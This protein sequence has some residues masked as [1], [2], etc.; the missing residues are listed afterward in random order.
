MEDKE[1]SSI[2]PQL[3]PKES[4]VITR[5]SE[6]TS[7]PSAAPLDREA[8]E[9]GNEGVPPHGEPLDVAQHAPCAAEPREKIPEGDEAPAGNQDLRARFE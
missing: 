8:A 7:A 1:D 2:G 6:W 9:E 3:D 5:P 4:K